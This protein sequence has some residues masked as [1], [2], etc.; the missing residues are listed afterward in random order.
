ML[1]RRAFHRK[2]MHFPRNFAVF[3]RE[4]RRS[5]IGARGNRSGIVTLSAVFHSA[6][7]IWLDDR[8]RH[9]TAKLVSERS[10][11][12]FGRQR[13]VSGAANGRPDRSDG[14]K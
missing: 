5:G 11:D 10:R 1:A 4:T 13:A 12:R 7:V 8:G 6:N 3:Q 9:L 2:R 14:R